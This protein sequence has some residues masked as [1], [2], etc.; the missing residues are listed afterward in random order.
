MPD[1][2]REAAHYWVGD[3]GVADGGNV[4]PRDLRVPCSLCAK[5]AADLARAL[6]TL[7]ALIAVDITNPAEVE[8][9]RQRARVVRAELSPEEQETR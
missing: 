1:T 2:E 7:D 5:T 9:V 6:A 8:A 4:P 3:H